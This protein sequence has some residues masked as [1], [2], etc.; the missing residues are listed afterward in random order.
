MLSGYVGLEELHT[1]GILVTLAMVCI[2]RVTVEGGGGKW[3][4]GGVK[5]EW[6]GTEGV[7]GWICGWYTIPYIHYLL[8]FLSRALG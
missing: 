7:E 5:G 1:V 2:E 8:T 3:R 4:N 6:W